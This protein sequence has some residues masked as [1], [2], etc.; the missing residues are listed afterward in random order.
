MA[1]KK[2]IRK[3]VL[4]KRSA[5][6]K[7]EWVKKSHLICEKVTNHPFFLKADEIYCYMDFRN[8]VATKE[9]LEFAWSHQKKVAVPKIQ[10]D[11]MNFYYIN[12]VDELKEGYFGIL[13]PVV[14][15]IAEGEN[16]LVLMPGAAYDDQRHRIGYGKG[17]YDRFLEKHPNYHTMALAFELQMTENI[18]AEKHD[19]CPEIIITE[20][21]I[22]C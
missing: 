20:E 19:I 14:E 15:K 8:E 16:V 18:P 13:E 4:V 1:S 17:F 10:G 3:H 7:N 11:T 5:M 9:I 22:L 12:G 2:D 6:S 21:R